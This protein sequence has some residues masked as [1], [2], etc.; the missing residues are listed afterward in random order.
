MMHYARMP[1]QLTKPYSTLTELV[2]HAVSWVRRFLL[3][4]Q[5]TDPT[6]MGLNYC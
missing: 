5:A 2:T 3:P 4:L 1:K 6:R